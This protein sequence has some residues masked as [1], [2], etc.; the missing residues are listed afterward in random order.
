MRI[1]A[2]IK[3]VPDSFATIK[4]LPDGSGIDTT[5]LKQVIDPFDEFGVELALQL[6]EKRSDVTEVVALTL[7][8]D[9]AAE[10]MLVALAMGAD[11]GIHINDPNF[12]SK[13]ELFAAEV[14]AR[15]IKKGSGELGDK[16]FETINYEGAVR[17][18]LSV[19]ATAMI[20]T[21]PGP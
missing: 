9:K 3:Q 14:I 12:E 16:K 2:V 15:A 18:R 10:A 5:G 11:S 1:L 6:R 4:V 21:P 8:P 19:S 7:G 20:A 13:N 17:L